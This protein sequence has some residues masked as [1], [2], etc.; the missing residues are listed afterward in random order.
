MSELPSSAREASSSTAA[1]WGPFRTHLFVALQH[2]LPQHALS[3]VVH[4][5]ARVRSEHLK[6]ALI[7]AFVRHFRPEMADA[8]ETDPLRYGSFNAFFTRALTPQARPIALEA[9]VIASP[10]DGTVSQ[11]GYLTDRSI[12]QAKGRNY[13]LDALL[14]DHD[15][16]TRRLAGGAFAT[17]YLAPYNYH[18][19]HMPRSAAL[20]ATWYVP[21]RLFSVNTA[22]AGAVPNLFARNE[23]VVCGFEEERSEHAPL[24]FAM[25]LVGALFVG[26]I[27]TVWHGDVAPRHPRRPMELPVQGPGLT[28]GKGDEMGRFNMGSTVILLFPRD[29]VAWLPALAA[30]SRIRMGEPLGILRSPS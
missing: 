12:L 30:G 3:R 11:I 22:T 17:L 28:L 4:R 16:W 23:R 20:R 24:C 13:S 6:N 5:L 14:G 8:V 9:G 27:A 15:D 19:I 7:A 1:A 10:V 25:V 18:R 21:G 2:A 29:A 26:S